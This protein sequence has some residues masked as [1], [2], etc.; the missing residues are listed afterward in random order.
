MHGCY[1]VSTINHARAG[2]L[3]H[4]QL[5]KLNGRITLKNGI[6]CLTLRQH[7]QQTKALIKKENERLL[8]ETIF[9]YHAKFQERSF[10]TALVI[11]RLS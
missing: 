11:F 5:L 3:L 1:G 4:V 7:C 8:S 2:F 9:Y 6:F 10:K